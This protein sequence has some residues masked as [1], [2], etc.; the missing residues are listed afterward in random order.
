MLSVV[1]YAPRRPHKHWQR[2]F[3]LLRC[4]RSASHTCTSTFLYAVCTSQAIHASVSQFLITML[5]A[6]HKPYIH[7]GPL[8]FLPLP[9]CMHLAGHTCIGKSDPSCHATCASQAMHTST[10]SILFLRYTLCELYL[11]PWAPQGLLYQAMVAVAISFVPYDCSSSSS[12]IRRQ[13]FDLRWPG[14]PQW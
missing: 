4:M 6:L 14:L 13:Q 1:L 3:S 2:Q 8:F 11:H 12:L 7:R 10:R 9:C 5:Y